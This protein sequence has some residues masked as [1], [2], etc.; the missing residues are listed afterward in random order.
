MALKILWSKQ[1]DRKFDK[2]LE[3]LSGEYGERVTRNFVKKVYNFLEILSEYPEIGTIENEEKGIRGFTIVKEIDLFYKVTG[4]K[5]IL[6]D[7]FDNRQSP[8][9]KLFL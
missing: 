2:I 8:E 6:L 7:F 4:D 5:I 1:A 3:Y 9:K